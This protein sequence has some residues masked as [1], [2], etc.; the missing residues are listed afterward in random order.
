MEEEGRRF[1]K[2]ALNSGGPVSGASHAL[3]LYLLND[4]GQVM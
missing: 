2:D 4:F 3:L 1:Q